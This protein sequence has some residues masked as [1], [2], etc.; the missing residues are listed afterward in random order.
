M[1]PDSPFLTIH[2]AEVAEREETH[3]YCDYPVLARAADT[4]YIIL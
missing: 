3:Y 2:I 4:R 1:P